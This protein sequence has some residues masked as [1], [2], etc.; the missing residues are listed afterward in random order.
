MRIS[1]TTLESF[2]LFMQPEQEWMTEDSLRDSILGKFVPTHQVQLGK[3]FGQVLENPERYA[4]SRGYRCDGFEFG[5]DVM[6]PCLALMDRRGVYEAKATKQY[7]DCTVV[8]CADQLV[9]AHLLEH[10]T[11]LSTFDAEKYLDSYQ[12]R[13]MADIFQPRKIT[14]HVFCLY[15]SAGNGVI[16]LRSIETL[17][18]YPYPELHADCCALVRQFRDY[19]ISRGLDGYL[20]QRQVEAA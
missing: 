8:A 20:R 9:G 18:L 16:E 7:D 12:W 5:E 11:T 13:F 2:R 14:Y 1:T 4:V 19:V 17:P 3:A 6:A 10:K 15:E